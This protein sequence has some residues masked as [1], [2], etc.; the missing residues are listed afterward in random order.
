MIIMERNICL[1]IESICCNKTTLFGHKHNYLEKMTGILCSFGKTKVVGLLLFLWPPE[2][3]AS[4]QIHIMRHELRCMDQV[5]DLIRNCCGCPSG[6]K[7]TVAPVSMACLP[8]WMPSSL[9]SR[10]L[11]HSFNSQ[12]RKL[13]INP[14]I[15][16]F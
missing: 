10:I 13:S 15:S 6:S 12:Q 9:K 7:A 5:S 16:T 1:M 3:W 8:S 11:F 2:S 4:D 14:R